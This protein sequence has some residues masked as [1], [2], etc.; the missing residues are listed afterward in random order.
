MEKCSRERLTL[1]ELRGPLFSS[2][3]SLEPSD[4]ACWIVSSGTFGAAV[5][6]VEGRRGASTDCLADLPRS[7][8]TLPD[9]LE[10][11][12]GISE[13]AAMSMSCITVSVCSLEHFDAFS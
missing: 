13:L 9:R 10:R 4:S 7:K 6:S 5:A 1:W 12:F 3:I 11:R 2:A 8:E